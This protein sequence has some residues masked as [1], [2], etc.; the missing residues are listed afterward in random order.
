MYAIKGGETRELLFQRNEQTLQPI[1]KKSGKG[2]SIGVST[3][4]PKETG[5]PFLAL[6]LHLFLLL[7]MAIDTTPPNF[8][9]KTAASVPGSAGRGRADPG[10]LFLFVNTLV[11]II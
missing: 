3:G 9:A 5:I 1:V 7:T 2:L 8:N 11:Y 4:L 10:T 6:F